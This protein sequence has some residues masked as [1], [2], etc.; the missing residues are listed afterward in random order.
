MQR[1]RVVPLDQLGFLLPTIRSLQSQ[2]AST[3]RVK[4]TASPTMISVLVRPF[5][6]LLVCVRV[7]PKVLHVQETQRTLVVSALS[8][9]P[10]SET[11]RRS[12]RVPAYRR[13]SR[14]LDTTP[15]PK[16]ID[17]RRSIETFVISS[18][19]F[20]RIRYSHF[21]WKGTSAWSR[22]LTTV[23]N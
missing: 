23:V 4:N 6:K 19:S 17:L 12:L 9:W 18:I 22:T 16:E 1:P 14:S 20:I 15:L 2:A 21:R 11:V 10:R 8:R 13:I 5:S 3:F 7:I